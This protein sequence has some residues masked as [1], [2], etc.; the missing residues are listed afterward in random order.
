MDTGYEDYYED[1]INE[2]ERLGV[3]SDIMYTKPI[4]DIF[5]SEVNIIEETEFNIKAEIVMTS[6]K[7]LSS[8]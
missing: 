2:F 8:L 4:A 5:I 6:D 7:W 1:W 3:S